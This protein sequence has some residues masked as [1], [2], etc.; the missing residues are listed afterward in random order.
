MRARDNDNSDNLVHGVPEGDWS[1]L[2]RKFPAT[3]HV[4]VSSPDCK[5]R[6]SGDETIVAEDTG[7]LAC[8]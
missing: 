8:T 1:G 4:F 6:E 3:V 5:N 7:S 2:F